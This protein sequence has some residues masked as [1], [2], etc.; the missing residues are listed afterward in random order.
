MTDK[1][2]NVEQNIWDMPGNAH[3]VM[4]NF[5]QRNRRPVAPDPDNLVPVRH[6]HENNGGNDG[7]GPQFQAS[8]RRTRHSGKSYTRSSDN[9]THFRFYP[10]HFRN[11]LKEAQLRF[12]LWMV[13]DQG[14]PNKS[15]E[16]HRQ[17][18]LNCLNSALHDYQANSGRVEQGWQVYPGLYQNSLF[19]QVISLNTKTTW[20]PM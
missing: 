4:E 3:D 17:V 20:Y 18:V 1:L 13:V 8:T 19:L 2:A 16:T 11:V 12:R 15:N 7:A 14:F 6:G 9:P 5:H 10:Q